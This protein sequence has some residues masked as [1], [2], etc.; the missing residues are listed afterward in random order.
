MT[1]NTASAYTVVKTLQEGNG[2][3]L[4]RAIRNT[5]HHPVVLKVIDSKRSRP[6][7]L[8]RLKHELEIGR[9]LNIPSVISPLAIET[10]EGL[11]VLILEDFGGESLD[12]LLGSPMD[13]G[14]FL[15][16][17]L[18]I[19]EAVAEVHRRN[20]VHK[21]LKPQN[22]FVRATTDEV[23]LADFGIASRLP[24][25]HTSPR[26][27]RHI[28]GSL[29][30]MSPEQTGRTN[31]A[32]DSRSDLYSLGVT[33]YQMLTGRLPFDARDPLEWVHSHI[34]RQPPAP[35]EVV[36]KIPEAL[37][38]IVM[39]LLAKTADER[40]QSARGLAH[41]LQR[42]LEQWREHG[43]LEPFPLGERDIA[44]LL[45]I[46][47]RLYGR[48]AELAYLRDAFDRMVTQGMPELVL[49][50]GNS[51]VGKS[52]LV[53][54]LH[55]TVVRAGGY[56]LSGKF[57]QYASN[58]PYATMAQAFKALVLDL[59]AQD[60]ERLRAT[61]QALWEALGPNSKLI[62]DVL[63]P[64]EHLLGKLS[65]V[66]ELPPAEAERRF[67]GAFRRFLGVF[68]TREHPLVL[69]LDDLQWADS[70][71]LGLIENLLVE[72]G[73]HHLLLLGTWRDN[74]VSSSH[75]L[76]MALERIRKASAPVNGM[77]LEPLRL[78]HVARLVADTVHA[79]DPEHAR[80]LATLV[81]EKTGGTPFFILQF[82]TTLYAERLL[83]FDE[84]SGTW[85]WDIEQIRQKGYT[86]NVVDFLLGKLSALPPP[87]RDVLETA[88]CIGSKG[89]I[90][91]LALVSG[92]S[93]EETRQ[94]LFDA[95]R[96][97]LVLSS[98]D[99][100]AFAHDRVQQA[101]YSLLSEGH[102]RELHLR[103]GRL[104]LAH[105]SL[106]E[107]EERLFDVVTQLD[108]GAAMV[109]EPQERIRIA[110]L[111]L[112]AARKAKASAAYRIAANYLARGMEM[113][114]SDA[115]EHQYT[116]AYALFL[117]RALCELLSG[118]FDEAKRL[119][120][121][122]LTHA[123]T[124]ADKAAV[125]CIQIQT[126]LT[127]GALG[128]SIETALEG[129][130]LFGIEMVPHPSAGEVEQVYRSVWGHLGN[131]PIEAILT[132]P[133][134]TD[135]DVRAAMNLLTSLRLPAF[136]SD[137]HLLSL[138]ICHAMLLSLRYGNAP[139]SPPNYA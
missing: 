139:A 114:D 20:V 94:D 5:D 83:E 119:F 18:R 113:L 103:I 61:K 51:G 72:P 49:V 104:L 57:E 27:P 3:R 93:E 24:R 89:R 8:E 98:R 52:A 115:W 131:R 112:R 21:D 133:P 126:H 91:L 30:Y 41:D 66:P 121:V 108:L 123:R 16:L 97:G 55:E 134:M 54:E 67:R 17:A 81:Y 62:L 6:Q 26:N 117:E 47:Q 69:F 36:P 11:P 100:Y 1:T 109:T 64:L 70:S 111:N 129:L 73:T 128:E 10:Y 135:P 102:R 7:D 56:F 77:L 79:V 50:G 68:A 22:I 127:R 59:L 23:K 95:V 65:P 42:C 137:L 99:T 96:E 101:A 53:R 13:T 87:V 105:T 106:E 33:Y 4:L 74:E 19:A 60:E 32:I 78:E 34:A 92:K 45:R 25:E 48:E 124:R 122:L 120:P 136:T 125:C 82:L 58:V 80:P 75:P 130:R 118:S 37:S 71:S 29:P 88:A 35:S 90:S 76:T 38:R 28:E 39:R 84:A 15:L 86:D 31:R 44:G 46:P 107:L 43:T 40:Y 12:H 110:E 132:Q 63:P 138:T 14:R 85:R 2:T 116:L 9:A